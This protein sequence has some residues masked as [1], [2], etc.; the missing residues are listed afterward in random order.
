MLLSS[1]SSFLS[2]LCCFGPLNNALVVTTRPR[3]LGPSDVKAAA[4]DLMDQSLLMHLPV[5][6][7]GD[8]G[9]SKEVRGG[10]ERFPRCQEL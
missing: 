9:L 6:A 5:D 4:E 2:L 10:L 1:C 3:D 8:S 7:A